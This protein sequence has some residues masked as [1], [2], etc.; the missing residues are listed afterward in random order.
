M[1]YV[2][3]KSK[4]DEEKKER[5]SNGVSL[6]QG[7]IGRR[8]REMMHK[9]EATDPPQKNYKHIYTCLRKKAI[10]PALVFL[11]LLPRVVSLFCYENGRFFPCLFNPLAKPT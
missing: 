3:K 4:H 6:E 10:K 8:N 1:M 9:T 7:S 5:S 11:T 2:D